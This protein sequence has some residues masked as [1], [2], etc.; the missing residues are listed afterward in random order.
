MN[1]SLLQI[2]LDGFKEVSRCGSRRIL[3]RR[4]TRRRR[5]SRLHSDVK[6][7]IA[8]LA[9]HGGDA[10]AEQVA[11]RL[12]LIQSADTGPIDAAIDTM[13]ATNPKPLAD[14]KAGKKQAL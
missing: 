8:K 6:A 9:E 10:P 5:S 1:K 7:L 2:G 13:I 4:L 14:Y 12:G 11:T 3:L